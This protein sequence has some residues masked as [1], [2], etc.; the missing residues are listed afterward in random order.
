MARP[1]GSKE[2]LEARRKQSVR[3]LKRTE[4]SV[5]EVAEVE[6]VTRQAVNNWKNAYEDD[7]MEGLEAKPSGGGRTP[8][9]S[10]EKLPELEEL[11]LKSGLRKS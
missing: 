4:M 6:D 8:A 2:D 1:D 5:S 9:L 10:A 11:L 3:L 7:G